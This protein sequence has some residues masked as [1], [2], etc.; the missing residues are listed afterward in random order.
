[1][2]LLIIII[3]FNERFPASADLQSGLKLQETKKKITNRKLIKIELKKGFNRNITKGT[4]YKSA[5][6]SLL[7]S[8]KVID[9]FVP[10]IVIVSPI[11]CIA[12]NH[13]SEALFNGYKFG[14]ELL[15]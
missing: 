6:A 15:I 10:Y 8:R 4:D 2:E 5:P 13:F 1:M 12:I 11:L 7:T 9:K 3:E 14:Y